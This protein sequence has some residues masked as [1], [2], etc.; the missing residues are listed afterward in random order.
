LKVVKSPH[1]NENS[2][3]FDETI[4]RDSKYVIVFDHLWTGLVVPCMRN[5][6]VTL[7]VSF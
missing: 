4:V 2:S 5:A 6:N 1:L 3:G 7:L